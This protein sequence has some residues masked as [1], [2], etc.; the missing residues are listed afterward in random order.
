[1]TLGREAVPSKAD[2]HKGRV[3]SV[4]EGCIIEICM[5]CYLSIRDRDRALFQRT[6]F[7][8]PP[9]SPQGK[10]MAEPPSPGAVT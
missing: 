4:G 9:S 1:M 10:A 6:L 8:L 5:F 2:G 7:L 3:D